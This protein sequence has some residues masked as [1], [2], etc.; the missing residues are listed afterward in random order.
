MSFIVRT[1]FGEPKQD[2]LISTL[3]DAVKGNEKEKALA[4]M[5]I[6]FTMLSE[7]IHEDKSQSE[8]KFDENN[9]RLV[10]NRYDMLESVHKDFAVYDYG[11]SPFPDH[12]LPVLDSFAVFGNLNGS[13][14]GL[15]LEY[16]RRDV[17]PLKTIAFS[18]SS[19]ENI[20]KMAKEVFNFKNPFGRE[21]YS[22][23]STRKRLFDLRPYGR[24][25]GTTALVCEGQATFT[26][27]GRTQSS[28]AKEMLKRSLEYKDF[29]PEEF[30]IRHYDFVVDSSREDEIKE[31]Q[32]KYTE[33]GERIGRVMQKKATANSVA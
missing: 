23:V 3:F 14:A 6:R 11:V 21:A 8:P 18:C 2:L 22:E 1:G 25:T 10:L 29:V 31:S 13:K 19:S 33:L 24:K 20:V 30:V 17:R 16:F 32:R 9:S 15:I 28:I 27:R 5:G 12:F 26:G 4:R 7:L